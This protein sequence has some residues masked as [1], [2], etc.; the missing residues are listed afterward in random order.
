MSR[1]DTCH[2]LIQGLPL[3]GSR[4]R[5]LAEAVTAAVHEAIVNLSPW[6]AHGATCA[7]VTQAARCSCGLQE[8]LE[9]SQWAC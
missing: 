8:E 2:A 6:T 5:G 9:K 7:R 1:L 3:E 4:R